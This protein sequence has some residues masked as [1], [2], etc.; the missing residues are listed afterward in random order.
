[1]TYRV[2]YISTFYADMLSAAVSLSEYPGKAS[3]IFKN[4]DKALLN[5]VDM[6]EMYPVYH[7]IPSYRLIVI[8]DY[9]IL[10]K[11]KKPDGVVEVHRLVC[12]RMDIPSHVQ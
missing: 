2:E 11:V 7:C 1:M 4:I 8:E 5:L 10:Y 3:R 9:L 12:G 6:P